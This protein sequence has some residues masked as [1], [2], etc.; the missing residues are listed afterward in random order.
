MSNP[1]LHEVL[2]TAFSGISVRIL[3]SKGSYF[4]QI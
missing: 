3:C 4:I 2:Q 1:K